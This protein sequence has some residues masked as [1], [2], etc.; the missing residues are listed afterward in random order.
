[1]SWGS[2]SG[3]LLFWYVNRKRVPE[4]AGAALEIAVAANRHYIER[5]AV[6]AVVVLICRAATVNARE[7]RGRSQTMALHGDG[8]DA[9]R[10]PHGPACSSAVATLQAVA[11][12]FRARGYVR[13]AAAL[14]Q[15]AACGLDGV[16]VL[17][18][19]SGLGSCVHYGHAILVAGRVSLER[20]AGQRLDLQLPQCRHIAP[21]ADGALIHPTECKRDGGLCP[22]V[23][24]DFLFGHSAYYGPANMGMH[25]ELFNRQATLAHMEAIGARIRRVRKAG[26]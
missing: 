18:H 21:A 19:G 9:M 1:M 8:N 6:V 3:G 14:T 15:S 5:S 20:P 13:N 24:D 16:E 11:R 2:I 4:L 12:T 22:V 23:P 10:P 7:L 17:R 26:R 25:I